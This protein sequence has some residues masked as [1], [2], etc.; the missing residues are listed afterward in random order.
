MAV[1][2]TAQ[3]ERI[4]LFLKDHTDRAFSVK[5]IA[6][7][8][9]LNSDLDHIPSDSTIY[10][11]MNSLADSG[12]VIRTVDSCREYRYTLYQYDSPRIQ[13]KCKLCG[14]TYEID[15]SVCSEIISGLQN[16]CP[17]DTDKNIEITIK[18][19]KCS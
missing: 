10:R 9:R 7:E 3:R 5:E 8:L 6:D 18:C 13:V 1:Y 15:D 2:K 12:E 4:M 17:I 16:A 11:I 14:K 19:D